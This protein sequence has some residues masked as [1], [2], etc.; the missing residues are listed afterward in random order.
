MVLLWWHHIRESKKAGA[1][2]EIKSVLRTQREPQRAV[3]ILRF[4]VK[5]A[6]GFTGLTCEG[7][8]MWLSG[9]CPTFSFSRSSAHIPPS[10]FVRCSLMLK[11]VHQ[12]LWALFE[13]W[14]KISPSLTLSRLPT[15]APTFRVPKTKRI[16]E[17]DWTEDLENQKRYALSTEPCRAK[18]IWMISAPV[19]PKTAS[20]AQLF[21]ALA[22]ALEQT[23]F[24]ILKTL[25][26]HFFLSLSNWVCHHIETTP[27]RK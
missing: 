2:L 22:G 1:E 19:L 4:L 10:F 5:H 13:G 21:E 3:Q 25:F 12:K 24:L 17:G 6:L 23:L 16:L 20:L 9:K 11:M 7:K 18:F 15:R 27:S 26:F 14:G 8:L